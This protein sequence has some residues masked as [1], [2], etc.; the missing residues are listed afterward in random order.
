MFSYAY[1]TI[2]KESQQLQK[3]LSEWDEKNYP[4]AR[5]QRDKRLKDL[6]D[7]ITV[8]QQHEKRFTA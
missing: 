6:T 4:E 8:L 5:K 7:A 1:Y 2:I 3:A